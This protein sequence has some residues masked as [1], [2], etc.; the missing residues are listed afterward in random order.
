M[1]VELKKRRRRPAGRPAKKSSSPNDIAHWSLSN[2]LHGGAGRFWSL[3]ASSLP[4]SGRSRRPGIRCQPRPRE[5]APPRP[6]GLHPLHRQALGARPLPAG[7]T[8]ATVLGEAG[9]HRTR[10]TRRSSAWQMMIEGLAM[11]S[12]ATLQ[13]QDP[14]IRCLRRLVQLVMS[15]EALSPPLRSPVGFQ[16]HQASERRRA[17]EGRGLGRRSSSQMLLFNLINAEQKQVIYA[18]Y[19]LDWPVGPRRLERGFHRRGPAQEPQGKH[20]YLPRP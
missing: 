16:D 3:S 17:Q 14:T 11:G 20:Q 5:E 2:L 13:R 1:I 6:A 19:G 12:F 4:H 18:K 9:E 7:Q 8:I 10:S 15:D